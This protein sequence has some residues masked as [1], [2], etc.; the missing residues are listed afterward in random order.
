MSVTS[1][2]SGAFLKKVAEMAFTYLLE[3]SQLVEGI[4]SRLGPEPE[5][6]AFQVALARAC[7]TFPATIPNGRPHFSTSR[8][9]TRRPRAKA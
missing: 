5:R 3:Q 7:T 6:L 9:L 1:V 2:L 4:R 8:S